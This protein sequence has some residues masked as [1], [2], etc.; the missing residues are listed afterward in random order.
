MLAAIAVNAMQVGFLVSSGYSD[1]GFLWSIVTLTY[2]FAMLH[3]LG[4]LAV[5]WPCVMA[6]HSLKFSCVPDGYREALNDDDFDSAA[7]LDLGS[8]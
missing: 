5:T 2:A 4:L 7:E 8:A 6:N 1:P 3:G